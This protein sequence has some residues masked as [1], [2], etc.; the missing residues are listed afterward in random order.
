MAP[1]QLCQ[2][3]RAEPLRHKHPPYEINES[4]CWEASAPGK[5]TRMWLTAEQMSFLTEITSDPSHS[6]PN[7][8]LLTARRITTTK[9]PLSVYSHFRCGFFFSVDN[10]WKYSGLRVWCGLFFLLVFFMGFNGG[11]CWK[12]C[13]HSSQVQERGTGP[14][15]KGQE[16]KWRNPS[17]MDCNIHIFIL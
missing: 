5:L 15:T 13:D 17:F 8:F 14:Q 3:H 1:H 9:G 10:G 11:V 6:E 12:Q 7:T 16:K 2:Q 4:P